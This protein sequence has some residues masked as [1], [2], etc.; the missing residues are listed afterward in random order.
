MNPSRL[1][2]FLALLLVAASAACARAEPPFAPPS[3]ARLGHVVTVASPTEPG[4]RMIVTGRLFARDG[5]TLLPGRWIGVYQTDATGEYGTDRRVSEWARLHGFLR[6]D[7]RGRFEIRTIRPGVYPQRNTP[8]HI[9]FVIE[10]P[11]GGDGSMEVQFEDDALVPSY[12]RDA[13]R[14]DGRFGTVRPV[15]RGK[16]GVQRVERDLR[17]SN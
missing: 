15:T 9:H 14:R 6:T 12:L 7:A 2:V 3:G 5:V 10:T 4:P 11:R 8:A 13:S 17:L 16:D 1:T